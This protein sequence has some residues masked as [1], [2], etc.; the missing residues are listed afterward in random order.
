MSTPRKAGQEKQRGSEAERGRRRLI[1]LG[2]L[3]RSFAA[4]P[5]GLPDYWYSRFVF[6][7]ALPAIYLIGFLCA[8]N[9]FLPLLGERGLLPF[10]NFIRV[11]PFRSSPSLFYFVSSAAAVRIVAWFGV[12]LSVST[13]R[14]EREQTGRQWNRR[15]LGVYMPPVTLRQ[16]P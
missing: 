6:E 10:T 7:R 9:Q 2:G 14:D 15:L 1:A 16:S 5:E 12:G 13:T 3:R 4:M 11:V 8:V